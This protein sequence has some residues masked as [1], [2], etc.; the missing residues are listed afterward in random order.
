MRSSVDLKEFEGWVRCLNGAVYLIMNELTTMNTYMSK[1]ILSAIY[2]Y[3]VAR[4]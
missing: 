3:A 4:R 2:E 1:Q